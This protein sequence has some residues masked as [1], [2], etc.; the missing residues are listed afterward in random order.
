MPTLLHVDSSADLTSSRTR[1]ITATFAN[2]WRELGPEH[3]VIYRDLHST[4][5][6][7]LAD[8]SLHWAPRLRDPGAQPPTE[9]EEIQSEFIDELL[10]ADV[11]LVG[12]PLY[13]YSLPSTL[14]AWIDHIHVPGVTAPFDGTT[15]PMAGRPAV[16]ITSQ[17]GSYSSD[18]PTAGWDHGVPVLQLILGQALGM[19]VTVVTASLALADRVP[20][21]AAEIPRSRRELAAAHNE[22]AEL[23]RS[24][25]QGQ[26]RTAAR[27]V[28]WDQVFDG[29][30]DEVLVRL[31]AW[32]IAPC[33]PSQT[34]R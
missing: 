1:S 17:G 23:A 24:L 5:P 13:N 12:A 32:Q 15:Q 26:A 7:H 16:V 28:A 4:P 34:S 22:A 25:G 30:S 19:S 29:D 8:A 21:L 3:S 9:A 27:I 31:N 33:L 2:A 10:S 11:L 20:A 14:K 18:S 6:P